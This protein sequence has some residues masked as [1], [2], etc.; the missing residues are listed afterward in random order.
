VTLNN[1]VVDGDT[2]VIS[3]TNATVTVGSGGASPG[4]KSATDGT[5]HPIDCSSRFIT[6]PTN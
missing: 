2:T 6:F 1:V 4:V 3:P 5:P